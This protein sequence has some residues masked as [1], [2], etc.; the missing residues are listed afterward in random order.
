MFIMLYFFQSATGYYLMKSYKFPEL[1]AYLM[2]IRKIIPKEKN[3]SIPVVGSGYQD[4]F[5][6]D[7]KERFFLIRTSDGY[8]V[9]EFINYSKGAKNFYLLLRKDNFPSSPIGIYMK[10]I[11]KIKSYLTASTHK[12]VDISEVQKGLYVN[13]FYVQLKDKQ[14]LMN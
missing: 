1:K 4:W 8:M 13:L 14:P 2:D 6:L 5:A 12:K 3:N 7:E 11:D 9:E 10:D